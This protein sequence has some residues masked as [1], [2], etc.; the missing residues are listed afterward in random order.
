MT[1]LVI[2]IT[3]KSDTVVLSKNTPVNFAGREIHKLFE[4]RVIEASKPVGKL[5]HRGENETT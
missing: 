5:H 2:K 1:V 4:K 3:E